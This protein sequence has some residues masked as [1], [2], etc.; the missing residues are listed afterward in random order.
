MTQQ[1]QPNLTRLED[2]MELMEQLHDAASEGQ[3]SRFSEM[4][5][6]DLVAYLHELNYLVQETLQEVQ[7]HKKRQTPILSIVEK[8]EKV[9]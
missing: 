5:Q 4:S 6:R 9:G 3:A 8:I 1:N 7:T 2:L